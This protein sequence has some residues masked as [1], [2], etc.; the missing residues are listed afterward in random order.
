MSSYFN[1]LE[2]QKTK[3]VD[4]NLNKNRAHL[5]FV[6]M[7]PLKLLISSLL[8]NYC[9]IVFKN[10]VRVYNYMK[11]LS[12]H[13]WNLDTL[14]ILKNVYVLLRTLVKIV[15]HSSTMKKHTMLCV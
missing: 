3:L 7:L 15:T 1:A 6:E 8:C 14:Q 11:I 2:K 9:F 10:H 4:Q 12:T 13:F 5:I